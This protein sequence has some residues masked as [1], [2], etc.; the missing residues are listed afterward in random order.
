MGLARWLVMAFMLKCKFPLSPLALPSLHPQSGGRA[1]ETAHAPPRGLARPRWRLGG[2][3]RRRRRARGTAV[4]AAGGLCGGAGHALRQ[5]GRVAQG[6]AGVGGSGDHS[7]SNAAV[8][9]AGPCVL[10]GT[11]SSPRAWHA[12]NASP[13]QRPSPAHSRPPAAPARHPRC[14]SCWRSGPARRARARFRWTRASTTMSW[15]SCRCAPPP[16]HPR[17]GCGILAAA[18]GPACAAWLPLKEAALL[19]GDM[20]FPLSFW[21]P[22]CAGSVLWRRRAAGP[23]AV[24]EA[25]P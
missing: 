12:T 14:T 5:A 2:R 22:A 19:F 20:P 25:R 18:R 1:A 23:P 7:P 9:A 17:V 8:R 15:P 24:E 10:L 11:P 3:R 13:I 4:A 6:S 21:P 16:R